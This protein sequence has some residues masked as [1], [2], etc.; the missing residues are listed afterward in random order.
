[1]RDDPFGGFA[2]A[3]GIDINM[4]DIEDV[5]FV[6][7]C[8]GEYVAPTDEIVIQ[9][10]DRT[11]KKY[12]N[13]VARGKYNTV[14]EEFEVNPKRVCKTNTSKP[15]D[16]VKPLIKAVK[17]GDVTEETICQNCLDRLPSD[18]RNRLRGT[19]TNSCTD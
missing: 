15:T 14:A 18:V 17:S 19:E 3:F 16:K 4:D 9:P 6:E 7:I 10:S 12:K 8:H 2:E 1:M 5:Y 13:H 11:I